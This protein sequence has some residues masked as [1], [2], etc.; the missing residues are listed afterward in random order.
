MIIIIIIAM[1]ITIMIIQSYI[2]NY[3][4]KEQ[5]YFPKVSIAN[6]RPKE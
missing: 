6:T 3:L 1:V 4:S 2:Y 5:K